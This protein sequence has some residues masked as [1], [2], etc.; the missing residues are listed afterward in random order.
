[1]AT[2]FNTER[3]IMRRAIR[4]IRAA[5]FIVAGHDGEDRTTT[6]GATERA[7]LSSLANSDAGHWHTD[8]MMVVAYQPARRGGKWQRVGWA[9]FIAGNGCDFLSDN[10]C[11]NETFAAAM[12]RATEYAIALEC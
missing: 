7:V 3:K 8:E 6:P 4:E 11:G 12:D 1:M 2:E 10:S 5:G 9:L